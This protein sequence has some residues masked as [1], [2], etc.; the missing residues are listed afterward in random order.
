MGRISRISNAA[1]V[2][3]ARSMVIAALGK[4]SAPRLQVVKRDL[5]IAGKN[6]CLL[7]LGRGTY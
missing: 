1:K 4:F 6:C 5:V 2:Y 3:A 7:Y